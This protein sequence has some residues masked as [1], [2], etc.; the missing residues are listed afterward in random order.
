MKLVRIKFLIRTSAWSFLLCSLLLILPFV[1]NTVNFLVALRCPSFT[2]FL[3]IFNFSFLL[4]FH[5]S[6]IVSLR[7]SIKFHLIWTWWNCVSLSEKRS[8]LYLV[9][10]L[11]WVWC[12]DPAALILRLMDFYSPQMWLHCV[13]KGSVCCC[14]STVI[15]ILFSVVSRWVCVVKIIINISSLIIHFSCTDQVKQQILKKC[16][17]LM[18]GYRAPYCSDT[19]RE[20]CFIQ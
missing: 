17:Y 2:I 3:I 20:I 1:L 12:C 14:V 11:N 8:L 6:D 19:L 7:R 16:D 4:F 18:C 15:F 5:C 13:L 10:I 9:Q